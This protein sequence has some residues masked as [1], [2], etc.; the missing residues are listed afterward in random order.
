MRCASRNTSTNPTTILEI[1]IGTIVNNLHRKTTLLVVLAAVLNT[2]LFIKLPYTLWAFVVVSVVIGVMPLLYTIHRDNVN[3]RRRVR[4][5]E[6]AAEKVV[7]ELRHDY[8]SAVITNKIAQ[9][10]V[11]QTQLD[12]IL[13]TVTD[14]LETDFRYER[15]MVLLT[16]SE[17]T[18]LTYSIG[19]G[20][21]EEQERYLKKSSFYL[22]RPESKA[23]FSVSFRDQRPFLIDDFNDLEESLSPY[24]VSFVRKLGAQKLICCPILCNGEC[25]GILAVD[26]TTEAKKDLTQRDMNLL[27]TVT[28]AIGISLHNADLFEARVGRL[29]SILQVMAASIDARDN[30]TAGHSERVTQFALGICDELDL[31][32]RY[33]EMIRVA[34]LLHDYGKIGIPDAILKKP[35]WLT[36][37][38]HDVVKSHSAKTREILEQMNFEGIYRLVPDIAGS[39]HERVDGTGYPN[40]L[41]GKEI[42]LGAKIIAVADFFEAITSRRH[43]RDPMP[44]DVA[45]VLLQ[46]K[47]GTH[48]EKK[49][50]NALINYLHKSQVCFLDESLRNLPVREA[51]QERVP[52]RMPIYIHKNGVSVLGSTVDI[53]V[54]GFFVASDID[55]EEG[56]EIDISFAGTDMY[57]TYCNTRGRVAWVNSRRQRRKPSMPVGFGVEFLV[58]D[59][60]KN[61]ADGV[62]N[63]HIPSDWYQHGNNGGCNGTC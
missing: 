59:S 6:R 39:H 62:F 35:G 17:K 43:Y 34:S 49:V 57:P 4:D 47:I 22:D 42:P 11:K 16:N 1:I 28:P 40:G 56:N 45:I 24:G 33:R 58:A 61:R 44:L 63:G 14:V 32:H 7:T 51:V 21:T 54:N 48:F 25:Y 8:D 37:E 52:C 20:Y 38:E 29:S 50:V 13:S 31:P 18:R 5:S 26:M 9:L 12:G 53:S 15:G 60:A 10:I 23:V 19:Y 2:L 41:K 27:M 3:L 46:E 36:P 55:V 30:L